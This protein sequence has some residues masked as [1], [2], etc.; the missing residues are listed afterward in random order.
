MKKFLLVGIAFLSFY[1]VKAQSYFGYLNDNY[2]GIHAVI[3]NPANI[4]DSRFNTDINLF[5]LNY[6]FTNNYY[7]ANINDVLAGGDFD[8]SGTKTPLSS[9]SFYQ[10]GDVLGPSFMFNL[11]PKNA[12]A[13]FSRGRSI[14]HLTNLDGLLIEEF[15][16]RTSNT[17]YSIKNQNLSAAA[18]AWAEFGLSYATILYDKEKHFLKGGLS[19]K[20]LAG[21]YSAYAKATNYG[22]DYFDGPTSDSSFYNTTGNLE[23]GNLKSFENYD[24][25]EKIEGNGFGTDIGFTYEFRPNSEDFKYKDKN[26]NL[27]YYKDKNKY[28][29]RIGVSVT[30]IGFIKYKDAKTETYDANAFYTGTQSNNS[31]FRDIYTLIGSSNKIVSYLPT[32]LHINGDWNFHKYLYLNV[33]TDLSLIKNTAA[34]SAYINNNIGITPRFERKWF[35]AYLPINYLKY[36]GLQSGFGFRA[37]PL[38]LGSGSVISGL[39]GKTQAID[40]HFGLKIPIYQGKLKDKDFD[41]TKDKKDDC[42][43]VAGPIENKGCPWKD[44]DSDSILD[45]DD[46]CP[47]VAGDK[48]NNGCPWGDADKD[49]VLDN[50]D[51]CPEISGDVAN[52][53]CPWQDADKDGITDNIDKCPQVFGIV[54]NNGCPEEA[55]KVVE[56]PVIKEGIIKKINDFSKTILFDT[57]KA[58]IKLESNISLDGI[59]SVLS[60]FPTA[61]FKIEGHTDSSGKPANNLKLSQERAD[62]VKQYLINKGIQATRLSAQGFGSTQPI[63]TN[64]TVEGKNQN[65]RVEINLVK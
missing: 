62:A 13:Y 51:K 18:N 15:N 25:P 16:T 22:V 55:K 26:G 41:D 6:L 48:T 31:N 27:A 36:S 20:Y 21:F 33:N 53:G 3:N 54:S 28:L 63:T 60:E 59:V 64:A 11:N 40:V 5:S 38:M 45:K 29:Y 39:I 49:S 30:D 19:L 47:D 32:A 52:N 1:G 61:N 42:P 9:N 44:S 37:G 43:D 24:N 8:E 65:R 57:G 7:A 56:V 10:S 46:K 35:S 23:S 2:A 58:T 34:N 17:N 4:V 14:V 12:I 50:V